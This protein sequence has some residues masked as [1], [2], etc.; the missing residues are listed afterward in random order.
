V[1][2][3]YQRMLADGGEQARQ[4][5]DYLRNWFQSA[6]WLVRGI[7]QRRQTLYRVT[8]VIVEKQRAF[9]DHGVDC[10]K[11]LTLREVAE[12]LG[13][14]ESTVSRATQNK[15]VQTPRGL[16]SFRYFFPSGVDSSSGGASA[17]SVKKR[18][19][20]WISGEDKQKPLSDQQI[21]DL[22][23]AEGIRISRR[24]VAKYREELGIPSSMARRR[25][26]G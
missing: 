13:M 22:L 6:V 19:S 18:I 20:E 14:H 21:A 26:D 5:A 8:Q 1:N 4:A 16:F 15:Y 25:Y 10:L 7:E 3:R 11:P 23:R 24:T 17:K 12:E 9:L 2:D